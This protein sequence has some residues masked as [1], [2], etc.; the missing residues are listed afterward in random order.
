M[1][2]IQINKTGMFQEKKSLLLSCINESAI[3]LQIRFY[4]G[5]RY[6]LRNGVKKLI[7]PVKFAANILAHLLSILPGKKRKSNERECDVQKSIYFV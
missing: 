5:F 4:S 6:L 1:D 7:E 3:I 2:G